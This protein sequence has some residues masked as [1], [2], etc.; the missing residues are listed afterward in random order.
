MTTHFDWR[1]AIEQRAGTAGVSLPE[2]TIQEIAEHLDE[3]Y[4]AALRE[5]CTPA[6]AAA[7]AR[8]VLEESAMDPLR[9]HP[10]RKASTSPTPV[11]A[12]AQ[13]GKNLNIRGALRLA[14]RQFRL[15]PGFAIVTVLVLALGI[16]ASTTVFSIVDSVLLRPLP[17]AQ[18][19]RLVTLWDANPGQGL[20]HEPLSPVTFM[21]YRGVPVFKDAAA[22]SRS[23]LRLNDPDLDPTRVNAIWASGNLFDVLGVRPRIGQGFPA[24]RA[25]FARN[26]PAAVISDRLWRLRY[27]ADLSIVGRQIRLNDI[28]HT[29]VGVMAPGFRFP[30]DVDVWQLGTWNFAPQARG[31]RYM[32][33]VARLAEGIT[34]EQATT[35]A[36]ELGQR[37]E[38]QFESTNKGWAPRLIP[39]LEDQLGYYRPALLVLIGAVGLVLIIGCLNVASLLLARA[40]TREREIAVRVAIGA[41]PRQVMAQLL[42][43]SF[44]LSSVGAVLGVLMA[45]AALPALV[46]IAPASIP[47]LDDAHVDLRAL[48]LAAALVVG[49]T[50]VFGLVPGWV[51]LRRGSGER[52]SGERGSSRQIRHAYSLLVAGQLALACSVLVSGALLIGTVANMV[53]TPTGVDAEEVVTAAI[54]L[55]GIAR[56]NDLAQWQMMADTHRMLLERVRQQRGVAAAGATNY[57]PVDSGWRFS[58][59]I[60][61]GDSA[62]RPDDRPQAQYHSVTDGYFETM[63]AVL[64]LGRSLSA[65]DRSAAPGAVVVNESFVARYLRGSRSPIGRVIVTTLFAVGPLG[66]NLSIP[67]PAAPGQPLSS[68]NFEIVG[69]VKDVRNVPVGEPVEPAIYF[70]AYQFPF[71][72]L[73]F[74]VRAHD[75]TTAVAAVRRAL[76]ETL[77]NVPVGTVQ[78]WRDRMAAHTAEPRL[79]MTVLVFFGAT[80][81][82]LAALGIHGLFSWS[83]AQRTRELAIRLT[84]GARPVSVGVSVVRDSLVLI[85][86]GL[87][88]GFIIVRIAEG[89]LTRVLFE[90]SPRDPAAWLAASALLGGAALG[91]CVA[92]ALRALRIDP[93]EG[94]RAE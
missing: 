28:P 80:A 45:L 14:V 34:Y 62:L 94:L 51:L 24:D 70:S 89:A 83:V 25:F 59:L 47:R 46:S 49:T 41:S 64:A 33:A 29:V 9:G 2:A 39:L 16:G 15:H 36:A 48:G 76:A 17:Y 63:G 31:A 81:A 23:S 78:T 93:V 11:P 56:P 75:T 18:P 4:A 35:A 12:L 38:A 54:Q 87:T 27:E 88:V 7:A 90:L 84:L 57:L 5:G 73:F 19:D 67:V 43:E 85:V 92:P 86:G 65:V 20:A 55:P 32:E 71:R 60:D 72:E 53:N 69:V 26:E 8:A 77:P 30:D 66:R 58:F 42:A 61:G 50:A 3:V 13:S 21:D 79:L 44:V 52:R 91:A 82:L 10:T 40:M 22:W 68:A 1:Q 37:L 74:T 6:E